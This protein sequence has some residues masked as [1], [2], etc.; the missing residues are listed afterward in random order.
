MTPI[1]TL[2]AVLVLTA[3]GTSAHTQSDKAQGDKAFLS[4]ALEGD[5]AEMMLGRI[6]QEKGASAKV[7]DFGKTLQTDHS[8]AKAK[9][10]PVAEAHGVTDSGSF[11]AEA[12]NEEQKLRGL[13]GAAFDKEFAR[14]MVEDHRKDIADFEHEAKV[15][16]PSAANLA[17]QTLPVL[18]KH[19]RVAESIDG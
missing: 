7:R 14:Y 1:R 16:A 12:T 18:R 6:A 19:L 3:L 9:L 13:S 8:S 10:L 2:A 15:G 17:R 5:N 11:P 4:K